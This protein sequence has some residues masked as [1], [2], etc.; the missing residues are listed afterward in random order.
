MNNRE[1]QKMKKAV[2]NT[3]I[4]LA[5]ANAIYRKKG[6]VRTTEA[7]YNERKS[8][9]TLV[10]EELAKANPQYAKKDSAFADEIIEHYQ[11]LLLFKLGDTNNSFQE[12]VLSCVAQDTVKARDIGIIASLPHTYKTTMDKE[13]RKAKEEAMASKSDFVGD[14]KKRNV[15]DVVVEMVKPLPHKGLYIVSFMQG[16][17]ILK[18]FTPNNPEDDGIVEGAG[19]QISAYVKDHQVNKYNGG[20]ETIVN[21]IKVLRVKTNNE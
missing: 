14:V 13:A 18:H 16:A 9:K 1:A 15:F 6:Y 5:V 3:K 7:D 17:N 10:L 20:K 8:N 19:L 4:A 11:G 21:R 2:Y 12:A